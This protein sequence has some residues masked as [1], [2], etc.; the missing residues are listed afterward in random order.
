[1]ILCH[2]S[3]EA[4]MAVTMIRR[5][6]PTPSDEE[7]HAAVRSA[8]EDLD[9][10]SAVDPRA[11]EDALRQA[12]PRQRWNA[13]ARAARMLIAFFEGARTGQKAPEKRAALE[14]GTQAARKRL[15]EARKVLPA[16][17][18]IAELNI[19]RQ[20]LSKAVKAHRLFAVEAAGERLYPAFFADAHLDRRQVE[21]VAKELG[22]LP[23]WQ[24]WE[25]F[26][27]PKASLGGLTPVEALK[28]GRYSE[29]RRA[30]IGF[31]ER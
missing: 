25:F 21:H 9:R 12:V 20:A 24:K 4:D 3:Q 16:R 28:R 31:A 29:T 11:L 8:I 17:E 26:T 18:L 5:K 23:G 2:G 7:L 22:E 10:L 27:T 13:L 15:V 1:M 19:T 6:P 14:A 30:A